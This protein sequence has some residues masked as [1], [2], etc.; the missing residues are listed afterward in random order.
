MWYRYML[1]I[2]Q[3]ST[4]MIEIILA[5]RI[6]VLFNRSRRV[7]VFVGSLML[8]ELG[9]AGLNISQCSTMEYVEACIIPR[10]RKEMASLLG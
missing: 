2:L 7:G 4:C 8:L 6:F 3:V 5:I 10:P 9:V 1:I